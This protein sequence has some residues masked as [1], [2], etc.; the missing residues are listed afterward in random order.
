MPWDLFTSSPGYV[1][2][3]EQKQL[4]PKGQLGLQARLRQD[5]DRAARDSE[6][7][8]PAG[9]LAGH[10]GP[11]TAWPAVPLPQGCWA[12]EAGL[13]PL[14]QAWCPGGLPSWAEGHPEAGQ[15]CHAPAGVVAVRQLV[16]LFDKLHAQAGAQEAGEG[17]AEQR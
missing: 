16:K 8:A 9:C 1:R 5:P 15:G 4:P 10:L 14:H 6:R 7:L 17:R 12:A 11:P 3:A 13:Q 2:K